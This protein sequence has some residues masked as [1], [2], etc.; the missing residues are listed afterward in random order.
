[1]NTSPL[2]TTV[3]NSGLSRQALQKRVA[4]QKA[5]RL[6]RGAYVDAREFAAADVSDQYRLRAQAFLAT[7]PKLQAWGITAAALEGAPVLAGALLHFAGSKNQA[8]SKQPGCAFHIELPS[9]H[10]VNNRT[11]QILFECASSSP[12]HDAL[13]AGDYLLHK[14]SLHTNAS[15][16]NNRDVDAKTTETL[17]RFPLAASNTLTRGSDTGQINQLDTGKPNFITAY[18]A[19]RKTSFVSPQAELLWLDFAQLCVIYGTRRAIRKTLRTGLLF[20]DQTESPAESLL[21]ARCVELGFAIPHLQVNIIEPFS[22]KHLGRV[23]GL[24]PSGKVQKG[25]YQQDSRFG[26]QLYYNQLGDNDSI[27]IEF[28]GS[29]KYQKDYASVLESE[30]LRQNAISNLGFRF[31]RVSWEDLLQPD[32]LNMIL[33]AAKVPKSRLVKAYLRKLI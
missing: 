9:E 32:K 12:L 4:K 6:I 33:K 19:M 3:S 15:L 24:W 2:V 27:I 18:Y 1:M 29:L 11:A 17:L 31:L 22:G 16:S 21:L 10:L 30:R 26:R 20:S 25:L 28:D 23:D 5:I 14:L 7:H 8:R 13:M